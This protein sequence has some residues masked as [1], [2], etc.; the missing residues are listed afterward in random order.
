MIP[1][2]TSNRPLRCN[3]YNLH[4]VARVP[5]LLRPNETLLDT[6]RGHKPVEDAD[7]PSLIVRTATSGTSERLLTNDSSRAFF[8]VIHVSGSVAKP[9]GGLDEHLS[10]RSEAGEILVSQLYYDEDA[11]ID[12]VSAY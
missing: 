12:P 8:V 9:I 3:P 4:Q 10:V 5:V 1:V 11:Y 7:T 2:H 6:P